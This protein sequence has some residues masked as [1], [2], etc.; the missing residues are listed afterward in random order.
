[1]FFIDGGMSDNSPALYQ[2]KY[3]T[4]IANRFYSDEEKYL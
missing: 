4:S 2:A 3:T 1:M